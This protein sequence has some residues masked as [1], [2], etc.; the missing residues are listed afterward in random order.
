MGLRTSRAD[1]TAALPADTALGHRLDRRVA[2]FPFAL[3]F[4]A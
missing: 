4:S 2:L 3:S 1:V